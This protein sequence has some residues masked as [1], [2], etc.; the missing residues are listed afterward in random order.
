MSVLMSPKAIAPEVL[1]FT[2]SAPGVVVLK[3]RTKTFKSLG[4]PFI[5]EFEQLA[6]EAFSRVI[7]LEVVGILFQV[8]ET[9]LL[10]EVV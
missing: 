1:P 4:E 6:T 9:T 3:E 5:L 7:L 2:V 10:I 8:T